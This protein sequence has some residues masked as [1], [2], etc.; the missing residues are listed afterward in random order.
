MCSHLVQHSFLVLRPLRLNPWG[1]YKSAVP[2]IFMTWF[3]CQ[4]CQEGKGINRFTRNHSFKI[5]PLDKE[6]LSFRCASL[7]AWPGRSL[8]RA[9][10]FRVVLSKKNWASR[11]QP[12]V[13]KLWSLD[14]AQPKKNICIH[15]IFCHLHSRYIC[16]LV[17]FAYVCFISCSC[18][19]SGPMRSRWKRN[20]LTKVYSFLDS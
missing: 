3:R 18:F 17:I 4:R 2:W 1:W 7:G 10:P 16:I 14:L 6:K 20:R 11:I 19:Q 13:P 9:S 5:A 15:F 12:E 8:D